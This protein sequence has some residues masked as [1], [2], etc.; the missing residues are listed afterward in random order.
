MGE[1][2]LT[3]EM[4]MDALMAHSVPAVEGEIMT[5]KVVEVREDGLLVDVGMKVESFI[6]LK[7]F[8]PQT[9]F[10]AGDEIPVL[11][12]KSSGPGEQLQVSW[13]RALILQG[14]D[15]LS[16]AFSAQTPVSGKISR[17][18]KGGLVVDL[19]VEAFLPASQVDHRIPED[20]SAWIGR[21]IQ[22]L[23]IECSRQKGNV[24]LSRRR[25][26]EQERALKKEALLKELIVGQVRHGRV[27]GVTSFGAF[28]DIGGFEGLLH[29]SDIR[30]EHPARAQ[31][32]VK[33]GDE[34]DVKI[35]KFDPSTQRLSLGRKQLLP[36]P[37]EGLEQRFKVGQTVRGVVSSLVS[38]G[39]FVELSPGIEGLVHV[40]ELSWNRRLHHPSEMLKLGQE[41]EAR[42]ISINSAEQ[43]MGLSLKRMGSSPWE[44]A[45]LLYPPGARLKAEVSRVVSSGAFLKLPIGVEGLLKVQDLSWTKKIRHPREAL[46]PGDVIEVV[47][48][49]VNPQQEKISLGLKQLSTDPITQLQIGQAVAGKALRVVDFGVLVGLESG[50][51]ALVRKSEMG[52]TL[53]TER[54]GQAHEG[55]PS[56]IL[57]PGEVVTGT[58]IKIQKK[59]RKVEI[60]IR[61][62][63][64]DEQRALMKKYARPSSG[65]TLGDAMDWKNN[66]E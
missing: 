52:E 29:V 9:R 25:L 44:E 65:P 19:G 54:R 17:R 4:N 47:V 1:A 31:D 57:T 26:L 63:D 28:I 41:V 24:V 2:I 55:P 38:F 11:I 45:A 39:A 37:W 33:V 43:K 66:L 40:S 20:L 36:H 6:P 58:V 51:E 12:K 35:L 15:K 60:S 62:H 49:E 34:V 7:E 13:R 18:I 21:E 27:T 64:R 22:A 16:R 53:E 48:L 61:R 42:I 10:Q 8:G 59:E 46:K 23:V 50:L 30:W 3:E 5:A 32:M 56:R 14:W